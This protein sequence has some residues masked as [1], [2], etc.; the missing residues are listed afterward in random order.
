[1]R[2]AEFLPHLSA[3]EPLSF[4]EGSV[5]PLGLQNAAERMADLLLPG[6]TVRVE[7]ARC[8]TL[9]TLAVELAHDPALTPADE[10]PQRAILAF[11][12]RCVY[13]LARQVS[14]TTDPIVRGFPGRLKA[15]RAVESRQPL[16]PTNYVKGP[17]TNG[18][19]GMH[20]RICRTGGL[21]DD[22]FNV[23]ARGHK[24]LRV[25]ESESGG[26]V[27]TH[28]RD[29]VIHNLQRNLRGNFQ[30]NWSGFDD[31]AKIC[32]LDKMKMRERAILGEALYDSNA[33][34]QAD[35][36]S[37]LKMTDCSTIYRPRSGSADQDLVDDRKRGEIERDVM[38]RMAQGA[39]HPVTFSAAL[40][41]VAQAVLAYE[42]VAQIL[43]TAFD[44]LRYYN[45]RHHNRSFMLGDALNNGKVAKA[46]QRCVKQL[47]PGVDRLQ[48]QIRTL[49]EVDMPPGGAPRIVDSLRHELMPQLLDG[50][51]GK[52][53]GR[54]LLEWLIA[55]H[56]RVQAEKSKQ[57]W[58]VQDGEARFR[59]FPEHVLDDLSRRSGFLFAY[60]ITNAYSILTD[61]HA[62]S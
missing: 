48:A 52:L 57:P 49:D 30:V 2:S 54:K 29:K 4:S 43:T 34:L 60:R 38:Q 32:R 46:V 26:D 17:A 62:L 35:T 40:R 50:L 53:S 33:G 28:L 44:S 42:Q 11:E 51:D 58:L 7:R 59:F 6:F 61:L 23:L 3:Y 22:D 56:L 1:M 41:T 12:R 18:L 36:L 27:W 31:L 8:L 21:F 39:A 37:R 20:F 25:W 45:F 24:L 19:V 15:L 9:A 14:K 13:A 10:S 55:R 5:D 16:T 47:I